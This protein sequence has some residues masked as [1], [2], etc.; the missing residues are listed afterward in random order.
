MRQHP[1]VKQLAQRRFIMIVH[2]GSLHFVNHCWYIKTRTTTSSSIMRILPVG[3]VISCDVHLEVLAS[4]HLQQG[5]PL[6]EHSLYSHKFHPRCLPQLWQ[7]LNP[8]WDNFS[9]II[10]NTYWICEV[11]LLAA[12]IKVHVQNTWNFVPIMKF[13]HRIIPKNPATIDRL[14]A[15]TAIQIVN[16]NC[17]KRK[18]THT[19]SRLQQ[20]SELA[21]Q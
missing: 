13:I 7:F 14:Y 11:Q 4:Y 16:H 1:I 3:P 21:K 5:E 15:P 12:Q 6:T 9:K 10:S 20:P 2:W 19:K 18:K 17:E 8:A